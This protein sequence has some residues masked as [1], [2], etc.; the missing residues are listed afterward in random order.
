[1][2]SVV[3]KYNY[4]S[5]FAW[6][7]IFQFIGYFIGTIT[8]SS[9]DTWYVGLQRSILTPLNYIFPIAWTALY[10]MIA[11]AGWLLWSNKDL[12]H[13]IAIKT[14][15]IFYILQIILNWLWSPLFFYY[16]FTGVALLCIILIIS[17]TTIVIY[18]AY[19]EL[20]LASILLIPYVAWSSFACYLNFYIW[21]YN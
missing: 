7:I 21:F 4:Y 16:H 14:S 6:I 17:F 1:M 8:K 18:K 20:S 13:S 3:K 2:I 9:I 12:K 15:K 10:I 5:L 11:T 19:N